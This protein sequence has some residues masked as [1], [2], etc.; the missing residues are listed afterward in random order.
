M[1]S[2]L[3]QLRRREAHVYPGLLAGARRLGQASADAVGGANAGAAGS[4]G[5]R[6][7]GGGTPE[8]TFVARLASGE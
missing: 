1:R 4:S 5:R 2:F 6:P 8:M 7:A 3:R